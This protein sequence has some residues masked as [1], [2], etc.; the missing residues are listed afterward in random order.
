M[1][2]GDEQHDRDQQDDADLEEQRQADEGR[3]AGQRPGQRVAGHL[4]DDLS[5]IR[6]APPDSASRPPIMAPSA[7]SSPTPPTVVPTPPVKLVIVFSTLN[8]ATMPITAA[9]STSGRNGWTFA[10]VMSST[11][12]AMPSRAARIRWVSLLSGLAS[13]AASIMRRPPYGGVAG[14]YCMPASARPERR[15]SCP[16]QPVRKRLYNAF[17]MWRWGMPA[18]SNTSPYASYPSRS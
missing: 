13:S 2:V 8:P 12:T 4:G 6:S 11:T 17:A 7:M 5:T 3:D 10:H 16:W 1:T 18:S 9:P 14:G 15:S